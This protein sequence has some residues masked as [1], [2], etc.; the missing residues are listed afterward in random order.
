MAGP[1]SPGSGLPEPVATLRHVSGHCPIYVGAGLVRRLE[2]VCARHLPGRRVAVISD[3]RVA[4]AVPLPGEAP[5]FTFPAGEGSKTRETWAA[6]TD[7]LIAG[8]F[9]RDSAVLAI[10]GGVVGDLAG[11]VAAT[12]HRGIPFVQVPTSLL[13]MLDASIGGKTGVD[14]AA[15][16]NLIGAFHQPAAVVTDPTLL[17]TLPEAEFRTGLAEAIKHGAILDAVH[18]AWLAA[19]AEPI[20]GRDLGTV[21]AMVRRSVVLKSEV[22]QYDEAERGRRTI[23]NAGHTVA[24]PLEVATG[25]RLSHG[26]AVA[27]GLVVESALGERLGVTE[28]GTA[29]ELARIAARFRLPTALPRDLAAETLLAV[30]RRDKKNRGGGL[31]LALLARIGQMA[32]SDAS[33]WTVAVAEEA[34]RG[35]L[36][37][38]AR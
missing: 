8:G 25:F 29:A 36:G 22:V 35:A 14:T 32:G 38:A 31:R 17:A 30:M 9:G 6:V 23:L 11:F 28:P 24:H 15:G 18:L 26:E 33:G 12:Y 27:I 5:V 13:A 34:V 2:E 10:G 20:L 16:K 7:G 21:D 3:D 4:A 1:T 37:A 19:A